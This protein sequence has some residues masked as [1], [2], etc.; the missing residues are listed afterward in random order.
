MRAPLLVNRFQAGD[1]S[2]VYPENQ[3]RDGCCHRH[4][5]GPV[6]NLCPHFF[7]LKLVPALIAMVACAQPVLLRYGVLSLSRLDTRGLAIE[8]ALDNPSQPLVK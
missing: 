1:D 7:S 8:L 3:K 2:P 6:G 4:V 5:R